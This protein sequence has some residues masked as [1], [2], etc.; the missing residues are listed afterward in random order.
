MSEDTH[1]LS[2]NFLHSFRNPT[3]AIHAFL[4]EEQ[5]A[6]RARIKQCDHF[7]SHEIGGILEDAEVQQAIFELRKKFHTDRS[8]FI[9][10]CTLPH[11]VSCFISEHQVDS[12][13][14][15]HTEGVDAQKQT[16]LPCVR[17]EFRAGN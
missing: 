9:L 14:Y 4:E 12:I 8:S 5:R 15:V 7:L 17:P 10:L 6:A 13:R 16:V 11:K 3:S 1:P 2:V